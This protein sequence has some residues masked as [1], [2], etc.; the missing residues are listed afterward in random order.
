MRDIFDMRI[1]FIIPS[2]GASGGLKVV[3][4]YF[5]EFQ[6]KGHDIIVYFPLIPYILDYDR[7]VW[8]K[9][10]FK[11]SRFFLNIRRYIFGNHE[12]RFSDKVIFKP[13]I[14]INNKTIRDA[15]VT[16]ATAWPTAYDVNKL[17]SSK[18]EKYYFVQD[19]E[20]WDNEYLGKKTYTLKLNKIVIANWL[21][22]EIN[23]VNH[24]NEN[25]PIIYNGV[26]DD[27][28]NGDVSKYVSKN[29]IN[30]LMLYHHLEKKGVKYGLKSFEI[31]KEK[32][33]NSKLT[34]FGLK[35]PLDIP[36]YITFVE[37]PSK[38]EIIEL[39]KQNE[40]YIFP[41]LEEGWGLTVF[42]AMASKCVVVGTDVG[43]LHEFGKHMEN[44][45]ISKPKDVEN[46]SN[47]LI[48]LIENPLLYK[49]ISE[50]AYAT[51]L[52]FK[53]ENSVNQFLGIITGGNYE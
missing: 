2:P 14:K 46:M 45:M 18:G 36:N 30:C 39:Y 28:V 20:I 24:I 40:I 7:G 29:N 9:I 8:Y 47:N 43:C 52:K 25:I 22:K 50:N 5:E 12:K 15:D 1:N 42:E 11:I 49:N 10:Y 51:S 44:A 34:M 13:V 48:K 31:I 32:Y 33:P 21:K 17:E 6:K 35:K 3:Y 16:I 4:K 27:F 38:K 23:K 26:D 19:F 37:N 41:S 53:W